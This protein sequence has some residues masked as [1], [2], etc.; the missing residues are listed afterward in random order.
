MGV[1]RQASWAPARTNRKRLGTSSCLAQ[2][3]VM[4][5]TKGPGLTLALCI[6]WSRLATRCP[7]CE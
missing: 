4:I 3:I 1:H 2:L 5:N 7:K 6:K